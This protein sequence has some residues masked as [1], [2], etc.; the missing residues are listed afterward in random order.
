MDLL[1]LSKNAV[2]HALDKLKELDK[3]HVKAFR[4]SNEVPREIKAEADTIIE[5]LLIDKLSSSY[6]SILSE[7][8]GY[9]KSKSSSN[10]SFIIEIV[11]KQKPELN[12]IG[13]EK[14]GG[15]L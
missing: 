13:C 2:A 15:G 9:I 10:L 5:K 1:K 4:Y 12:Q 7:E 8:S 14:R 11:K 6:L 3:K